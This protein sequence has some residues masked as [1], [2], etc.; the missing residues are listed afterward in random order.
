[1][2]SP[3]CT[4]DIQ[5]FSPFPNLKLQEISFVIHPGECMLLTG[6]NGSGKTTLLKL[7]TGAAPRHW[8]NLLEGD[9]KIPFY[10]NDQLRSVFL[11]TYPSV[12]YVSQNPVS[13]FVAKTAFEELEAVLENQGINRNGKICS[14]VFR[15]LHIEQSRLDR[16][17]LLRISGGEKRKIALAIA[18]CMQRPLILFDEPLSMLDDHGV[19]SVLDLIQWLKG[20]KNVAICISTHEPQVFRN[21][22]DSICD[23]DKH[24]SSKPLV[25]DASLQEL[26]QFV[27]NVKPKRQLCTIEVKNL[28]WKRRGKAVLSNI[29]LSFPDSA[30]TLLGGPNGSGKTSLMILLAGLVKPSKGSIS[31]DPPL[32]EKSHRRA[33]ISFQNPVF[34]SLGR[35]LHEELS[36]AEIHKNDLAFRVSKILKIDLQISLPHLSFG[37]QKLISLLKCLRQRPILLLDEPFVGL[38]EIS[39]DIARIMVEIAERSHRLSITTSPRK[40]DELLWDHNVLLKEGRVVDSNKY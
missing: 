7:L 14:D 28:T 39:A 24:C 11:G 33:D 23:L 34:D 32:K 20:E 19:K 21:I 38:D 35:T 4:V 15:I 1:M 18:S 36:L 3:L 2:D 31:F 40:S 30:R 16:M 13:N 25:N 37:Q 8:G 26:R 22:S 6:R 10:P 12:A 29:D 17:E 9:V 27:S 5:S